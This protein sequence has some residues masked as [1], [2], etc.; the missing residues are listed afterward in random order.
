[1]VDAIGESLN[2]KSSPM[3]QLHHLGENMKLEDLEPFS[4]LFIAKLTRKNGK[5]LNRVALR[6]DVEQLCRLWETLGSAS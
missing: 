4:E 3:T 6:I 5:P 2:R 1:M